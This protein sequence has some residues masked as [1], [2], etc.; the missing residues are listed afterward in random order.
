VKTKKEIR[1][2]LNERKSEKQ[3]Y[4]REKN[5]A[6]IEPAIMFWLI[7]ID[8]VNSYISALEWVLL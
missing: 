6:K 2:M 5:K 1:K 7:Q 8:V 3:R 4:I